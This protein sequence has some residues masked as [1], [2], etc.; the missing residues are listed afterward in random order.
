MKRMSSKSFTSGVRHFF[1]ERV[2]SCLL[3][4]KTIEHETFYTY[5]SVITT[6][7]PS[8]FCS[9]YLNTINSFADYFQ[10]LL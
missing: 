5:W 9:F 10:L 8:D 6:K 1:K 7:L 3:I 4:K 2:K